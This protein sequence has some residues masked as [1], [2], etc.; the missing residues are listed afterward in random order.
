MSST[1]SASAKKLSRP[2]RRAALVVHVVASASWLGLTVG[3]LALAITAGATGSA[4]TVEASVR[5]MKLFADWLLLPVAFLTLVSGLVLSLGTQWGLARHRWVYVK[6]WLTLATTAAT[7]FALRPG[8]GTTVS[9][10]AA[11][12]PLPDPGDLMM[13]PI[14]SLSAYVFMTVISV[15]KPWGLTRRGRRLRDAS[16]RR[17]NGNTEPVRQAA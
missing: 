3:L 6:F 14:V 17:R 10:V 11:G 15:L 13:G 1:S 2:A 9:A 4:V 16:T 7:A 12:E 8:L 5:A